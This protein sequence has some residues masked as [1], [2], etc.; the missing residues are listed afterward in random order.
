MT[1][2]Q[3]TIRS[4]TFDEADHAGLHSRCLMLDYENRSCRINFLQHN[5][6]K[7]IKAIPP[8]NTRP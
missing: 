7:E 2:I 6:L 5:A 3:P 4:M 1:A 8:Q